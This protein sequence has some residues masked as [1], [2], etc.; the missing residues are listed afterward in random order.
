M[1]RSL[2]ACYCCRLHLLTMQMVCV[3][4]CELDFKMMRMRDK[5]AQKHSSEQSSCTS[6]LCHEHELLDGL[7][8]L[9]SVQM[10]L[11]SPVLSGPFQPAPATHGHSTDVTYRPSRIR[12]GCP[13][14]VLFQSKNSTE[15]NRVLNLLSWPQLCIKHTK[16]RAVLLY[17][18]LPGS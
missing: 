17:I 3:H 7:G 12:R 6:H 9:K 13:S 8:A 14:L 10:L 2:R 18:Y 4:C 11:H 1:K 15:V 5:C 16:T